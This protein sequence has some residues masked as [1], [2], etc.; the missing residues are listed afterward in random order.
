MA[1]IK[2][3]LIVF[4]PSI[5][6]GGV[7]KNL[8]LILNYLCLK[9]ES[10]K[11]ITFD[12][13]SANKI[14]N[15]IELINPLFNFSFIKGRYLKYIFCLLVL[16]KI[17]F[18]SKD[19][20]VLSFQANIFVIMV[21]KFLGISVISRSNSSSTGWSKNR[22]KH[23]IFLHYLKK[24]DEVIVNSYKFKKEMDHRYKINA[25]C[26]LNPFDFKKIDKSSKVKVKKIFKRKSIKLISVGRLTKQK[27]FLTILK[28]IKLIETKD[29]ELVIIGKG[30]EENNLKKYILKNNLVNKIR[31]LGYKSNPFPYVKQA[32]IFV[33]SS[34]FE[35]S[36]NVLVE[37][38][39]L[40]KYIVSTDCHTG[41]KEILKNGKYGHLVKVGDSEGIA[42]AIIN[43]KKN[44][45]L[46][47]KIN[48]GFKSLNIYSYK[49]NT[50]KYYELISKYL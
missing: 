10:I 38:L 20:T 32:D 41:P 4:I 33:L 48:N 44:N 26:I 17:I 30:E 40:K 49:K 14:N 39:F 11:L 50:K 46:K 19:Y 5:E 35:G 6:D 8:F 12:K 36:P 27:D 1:K 24:A 34:I 15:K 28:A 37:A 22:F 45:Y 16:A 2:K 23:L 9:I 31:L 47:K 29:I 3:K 7:E 18:F 43:Y 25:K 21:S 13:N 42:K